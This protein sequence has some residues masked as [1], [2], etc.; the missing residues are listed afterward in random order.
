MDN[1]D[2]LQKYDDALAKIQKLEKVLVAAKA[3]REAQKIYMAHRGNQEAGKAVAV[4]AR[5]LDETF[6]GV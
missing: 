6:V 4:A 5:L 1:Q 3:L 2:L